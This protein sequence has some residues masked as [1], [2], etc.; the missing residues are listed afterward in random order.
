[1]LLVASKHLCFSEAILWKAASIGKA[2]LASIPLASPCMAPS[3]KLPGLPPLTLSLA[4]FNTNLRTFPCVLS[5][6][7][8]ERVW[9]ENILWVKVGRMAYAFN[10]RQRQQISEFEISLL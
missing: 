6:V 3:L 1:M 2:T 7:L 9:L 10:A 5:L 8:R 4:L